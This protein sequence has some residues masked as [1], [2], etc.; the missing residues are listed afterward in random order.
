MSMSLSENIS[1]EMQQNSEEQDF[2][3]EE[4][5]QHPDLVPSLSITFDS[6]PYT[7]T[8]MPSSP[9]LNEDLTIIEKKKVT[10][11]KVEE[12]T[13]KGNGGSNV[14]TN[15]K[16][17]KLNIALL[18]LRISAFVLCLKSF[19][20][21]AANK[22]KYEIL[23]IELF[24]VSFY[25]FKE[26]KYSLSVSVIACAYS[27]LQICDLAKYLI[28][29]KHTMEPKLRGYLNF[30]MDQI[31]T[32]LLM[33]A[34]SSAATL[35]YYWESEIAPSMLA[36]HLDSYEMAA[37]MGKQSFSIMA[38]VSAAFSFLAFVAFALTS[39]VSGYILF[40]V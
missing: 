19:A 11:E 26:F 5:Q 14:L 21:L 8:H 32:Y 31:L 38:N 9:T 39:L 28:T 29:K 10:I 40:K 37:G 20:V 2:E 30:A 13:G 1:I 12:G 6:A 24:R 25:K 18:G 7:R 3:H 15:K 22:Q 35:A 4:E 17:T 23:G 27:L 16:E 33:S 36:Y 34:S